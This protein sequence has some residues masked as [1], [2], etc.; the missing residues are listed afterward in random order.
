MARVPGHLRGLDFAHIEALL[1]LIGEGP[2]QGRLSIPGGWEVV[3][4]YEDLRLEKSSRGFKRFCYS[5]SFEIGTPMR[6]AESRMEF[7]SQR[8]PPSQA[9]LP[10]NLTEA[11]FDS[12]KVGNILATQG[13]ATRKQSA[14]LKGVGQA[15]IVYE[16]I[17]TLS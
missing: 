2:A 3:R 1:R 15:T 17:P 5:Y 9:R 11:I 8:V 13:Y 4:E 14:L 7:T 10:A 6:I 16:C 12:P